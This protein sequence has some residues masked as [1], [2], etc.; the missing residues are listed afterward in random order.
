MI[1]RQ[2][3]IDEIQ[4]IDQPNLEILYHI[5][6]ALKNSNGVVAEAPNTEEKNLLK[7]SILYEGDLLS[8]IDEAWEAEL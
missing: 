1:S 7:G 6:E 5:I 8:P 3:I 2:Q 4:G